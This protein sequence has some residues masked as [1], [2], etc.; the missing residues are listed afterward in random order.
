MPRLIKPAQWALTPALVDPKWEWFWRKA[1]FAAPLWEGGGNVQDQT[2]NRVSLPPSVTPAT[3]ET[4]SRGRGIRSNAN[5]ESFQITTPDYLKIG[6]PASIFCGITRLGSN[7]TNAALFGLLY[8]NN[9]A[10]PFTSIMMGHAASSEVRGEINSGG[11][12]RNM[13]SDDPALD[14]PTG[15]THDYAM[16]FKS[17]DSSAYRDG[18]LAATDGV[19]LSDPTYASTS[20]VTFGD[21][22]NASRTPNCDFHYGY[23]LDGECTAGQVKQ[24]ADDPHGP[25]RMLDEVGVVIVPAAVGAFN[26]FAKRLC[27]MNFGE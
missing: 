12:F 2:P 23:I 16:V 26:T 13:F 25:F 24:I 8:S 17:G 9:G 3:W 7:S 11:S 21:G 22:V 20:L 4:S 1:V 18:I 14:C 5:S 27:M 10:N 15:E 6:W 19:G